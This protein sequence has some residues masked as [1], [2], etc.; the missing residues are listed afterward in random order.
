MPWKQ[1]RQQ[2]RRRLVRSG[3]LV[4]RYSSFLNIQ[5]FSWWE[6]KA[7]CE[8]DK[9]KTYSLSLLSLFTSLCLLP[10]RSLMA[11]WL[12]VASICL[13]GCVHVNVNNDMI[14]LTCI[15][16][17]SSDHFTWA[18]IARRRDPK[19]PLP[20]LSPGLGRRSRGSGA[21][22]ESRGRNL[23]QEV[24]HNYLVKHWRLP[25]DYLPFCSALQG[26]SFGKPNKN[27]TFSTA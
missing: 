10:V 15:H 19:P 27:F 25:I 3:I 4:E 6:V 17:A 5:H 14:P 11:S 21:R 7:D 13:G 2:V 22:G 1:Q 8:A 12:V 20:P 24:D 23:G 18:P 16:V 26:I 9:L